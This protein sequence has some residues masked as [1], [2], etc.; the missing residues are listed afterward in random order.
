MNYIKV[1]IGSWG[2]Y[3]ECNDRALGSKWLD[4]ADYEDWEEIE[5][6]LKEEGFKLDG[7]DEELFIQDI[8]GICDNSINWD[9]M[10][11]KELFETLKESGVLDDDYKYE[12]MTAYLEIRCWSDFKELVDKDGEYWD[13]DIHYYKGYDWEDY[14]REMFECCGYKIPEPIENFIDFEAY[15]KYIGDCYAE[16]CENGIIEICA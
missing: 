5:T 11:P 12:E 16:E 15:G 3:N 2:S 10:H 14:G 8:E 1:V 6:E 7:I 13:N 4:L 9:H